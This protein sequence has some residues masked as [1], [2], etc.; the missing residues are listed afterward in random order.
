MHFLFSQIY[1]HYPGKSLN[2]G[3]RWI[4]RLMSEYMQWWTGRSLT[5]GLWHQQEM[6]VTLLT[7]V[8]E[9]GHWHSLEWGCAWIPVKHTC[10]NWS[11][12]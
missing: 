4:P 12:E 11:V 7:L 3:G 1:H 8:Y 10:K 6:A 5:K 9:F 2:D